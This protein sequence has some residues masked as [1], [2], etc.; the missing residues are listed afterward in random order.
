MRQYKLYE[1]IGLLQDDKHLRFESEK[2]FIM[3]VED[4]LTFI[5]KRTQ[6]DFY[7][8]TQ[9]RLHDTYTVYNPQVSCIDAL[10]AFIHD[11]KT[12]KIHKV[13]NV[14]KKT[15][16]YIITSDMNNFEFSL[17]DLNYGH[18]YILD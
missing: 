12:I 10:K 2:Y 9:N 7:S 13:D 4:K 17:D 14:T 3:M 6:E 16:D 8:I 5:D 15:R 1:I 18:W 11:G